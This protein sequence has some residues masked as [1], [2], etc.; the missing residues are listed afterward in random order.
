MHLCEICGEREAIYKCKL[1]GRRTCSI[2]FNLGKGICNVCDDALCNICGNALSIGY[3]KIC[4][5]IG[6]ED[7]LIQVSLVEYVCKNCFKALKL[8]S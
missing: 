5:R 8:T 6:C 4:G 3:C 2:D 1:C 7:C